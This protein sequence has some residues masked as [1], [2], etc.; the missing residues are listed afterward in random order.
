MDTEIVWHPEAQ[1][2]YRDILSY[3]LDKWSFEVADKFTSQIED[4][5]Q[6]LV[7]HHHLGIR[8]G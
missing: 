3:L 1:E 4:S 5:L 7:R 2:D 6:L 8:I